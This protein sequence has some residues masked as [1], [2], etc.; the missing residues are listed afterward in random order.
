MYSISASHVCRLNLC[1]AADPGRRMPFLFRNRQ[2]ARLSL[3]VS[4]A[5]SSHKAA[6]ALFCLMMLNAS[7]GQRLQVRRPG[8]ASPGETIFHLQSFHRSTWSRTCGSA[9]RAS[10]PVPGR[11]ERTGFAEPS[12]RRTSERLGRSCALREPSVATAELRG[13]VLRQL[14]RENISQSLPWCLTG[15]AALIRFR[16][17][18]CLEIQ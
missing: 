12:L 1:L 15:S 16:R 5:S 7:G 18:I 3:P 4:D 8:P 2:H 17:G 9:R 10:S 11:H 6:G 14:Y 13:V